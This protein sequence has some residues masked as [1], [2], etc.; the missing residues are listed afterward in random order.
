[1]LQRTASTSASVHGWRTGAGQSLSQLISI[2]ID[3]GQHA[4]GMARRRK[5]ATWGRLRTCLKR[6]RL[7][8]CPTSVCCIFIAT[9]HNGVRRA[10]FAVRGFPAT[11][12]GR[13]VR[14]EGRFQP[15][16]FGRAADPIPASVGLTASHTATHCLRLREYF[17]KNGKSAG[18]GLIASVFSANKQWG[19]VFS[20]QC[21][22]F[23]RSRRIR[24]ATQIGVGT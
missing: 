14:G 6:G 23:S 19:E 13:G 9:G 5:S 15:K 7:A 22:V 4:I 18:I 11:F 3:G 17:N 24:A 12:L 20:F 1:M 10:Y 8:I 16:L 2:H 21:S